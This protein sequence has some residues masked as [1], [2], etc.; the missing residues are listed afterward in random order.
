MKT[1]LA[2]VLL[3]FT[4]KSPKP[5]AQKPETAEN[6]E[7]TEITKV[8]IT[9]Y[10]NLPA[11][12][13]SVFSIQLGMSRAEAEAQLD[14]QSTSLYYYTDQRHFTEDYRIYVYDRDP[15]GQKKNCILYLIW[16]DNSAK[17]N[18]IVFYKDMEPYLQGN[19]KQLLTEE[20]LNPES[21]IAKNYLGKAAGSKVTLDVPVIHL[22]H[23]TY[24]Y[25]DKGL[26][27]T[28]ERSSTG[29]TVRFAFSSAEK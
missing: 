27:I 6:S 25:P 26:E 16:E 4:C 2:L 22:K 8:D 15:N 28:D 23:T 11:S 5:A 9:S 14:R 12:D 13:V 7:I 19:T 3:L 20:A 21:E 1:C 17:L 18:R 24:Y 29:P 10:P